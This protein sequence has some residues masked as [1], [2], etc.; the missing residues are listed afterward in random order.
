[1]TR[2]VPAQVRIPRINAQSGLIP[3]GLNADGTIQVPPLSRPM[4]AGWYRYG[5]TPGEIGPAVLLGHVDGDGRKGIFH[6]LKNLAPG[7]EIDVGRVDGTTAVFRVN[8]VAE[9]PKSSFPTD[10]VYGGTAT[11]QLRLIT[12][13]GAVNLASHSFLD[14]IIVYADLA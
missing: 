5:A 11:P 9:V 14:N 3:L 2:S 13:G 7:D 1:M 10:A 6:D 4:Q 8:H 12:C